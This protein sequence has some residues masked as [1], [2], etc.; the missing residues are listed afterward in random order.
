MAMG[1]LVKAAILFPMSQLVAV[2]AEGSSAVFL[3]YCLKFSKE[4]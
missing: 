2:G 1:A 4:R 3:G